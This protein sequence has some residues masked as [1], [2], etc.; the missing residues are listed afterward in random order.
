MRPTVALA[1]L[2]QD[3]RFRLPK[4]VVLG[5]FQ[6]YGVAWHDTAASGAIRLRL[7]LDGPGRV[8]RL[9]QDRRRYWRDAGPERTG[10][11]IGSSEPD[12]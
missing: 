3:N 2:G 8:Q 1:G 5:R 6:R 10:Y 4:P 7:A 12:R 11:A 9:R